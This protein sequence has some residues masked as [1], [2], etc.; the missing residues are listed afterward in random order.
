[1]QQSSLAMWQPRKCCWTRELTEIAGYNGNKPLHI[2]TQKGHDKIISLLLD[3]GAN[4]ESIAENGDT[5]LIRAAK[6]A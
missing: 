4:L 5:A 1:M 6:R 3:K 2:A